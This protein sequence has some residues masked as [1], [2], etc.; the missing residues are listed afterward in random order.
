M[1][2]KFLQIK[3][4]TQL[5]GSPYYYAERLGV[6]SVAFILKKNSKYGLIKEYKPPINSFLTTAFGGSIDKDLSLEDIVSEEVKEE[7]GFNPLDILFVGRTF[8]STQM[9]QYCLL[10]VV[11]VG[12]FIGSN[13]QNKTE[14]TAKVVWLKEEE[15][16]KLNDWK[17]ITIITKYNKLCQ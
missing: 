2:N 9:N 12:D 5:C 7:S 8:V 3:V 15:I 13:P 16:I 1:A 6:N 17:A 10:Y 11:E 4:C 14:A